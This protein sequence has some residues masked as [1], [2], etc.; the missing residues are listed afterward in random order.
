MIPLGEHI[1]AI[2]TTHQ[3]TRSVSVSGRPRTC[4]THYAACREAAAASPDVLRRPNIAFGCPKEATLRW[5]T[6]EN[7]RRTMEYHGVPYFRWRGHIRW[8]LDMF[9][10][11]LD[12]NGPKSYK[13]SLEI[14]GWANSM[15]NITG[16]I[17]PNVIPNQC[18]Q[19][20]ECE[21]YYNLPNIRSKSISFRY[22]YTAST[23]SNVHKA[24]DHKGNI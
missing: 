21:T 10:D 22:V 14:C 20:L 19:H 17:A 8:T 11:F 7:H 24:S 23:A 15:N 6:M 9:P 3:G 2:K 13:K 1:V 16:I 5:K 18:C 4:R 12:Q